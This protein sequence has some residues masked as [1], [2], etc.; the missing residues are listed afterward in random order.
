MGNK[1]DCIYFLSLYKKRKY[2][3]ENI[4]SIGGEMLIFHDWSVC[5]KKKEEVWEEK[6]WY[7]GNLLI[8]ILK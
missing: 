7:F 6:D 5:E 8:E 1:K 4:L 3:R 2:V